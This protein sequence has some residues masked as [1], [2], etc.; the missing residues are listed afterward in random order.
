MSD[1]KTEASRAG[2]ISSQYYGTLPQP[3]TAPSSHRVIKRET[4]VPAVVY[5]H[6]NSRGEIQFA[7]ER[8]SINV[9]WIVVEYRIHESI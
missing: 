7:V 6:F 9:D 4:A 3:I 2:S 5:V 8:E 1:A